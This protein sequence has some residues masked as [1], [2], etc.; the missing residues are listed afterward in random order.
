MNDAYTNYQAGKL[1]RERVLDF[2]EQELAFWLIQRLRE[3]ERDLP[4]VDW[5]H[6]QS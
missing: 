5:Y 2:D 1:Q 6:E 4:V 3:S